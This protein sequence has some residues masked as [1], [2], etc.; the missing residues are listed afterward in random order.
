[1]AAVEQRNICYSLTWPSN[2]Y[3]GGSILASSS[4]FD[5]I[6]HKGKSEISLGLFRPT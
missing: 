3:G 5:Q 2:Q 4:F 6:P 1:M